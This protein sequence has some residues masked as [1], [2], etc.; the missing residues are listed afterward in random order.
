MQVHE[1]VAHWKVDC[2]FDPQDGTGQT[3]RDI[4]RLLERR[5]Y[6]F[7]DR[8]LDAIDVR[9]F[10]RVALLGILTITSRAARELAS[11][12][13]F[14]KRVKGHLAVKGETKHL[15][16]LACEEGWAAVPEERR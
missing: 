2:L 9:D 5:E 12:E 1:T 10:A 11:R 3:Y 6:D 14:F 16:G 4:Y 15:A 7:V 8:C 13:G